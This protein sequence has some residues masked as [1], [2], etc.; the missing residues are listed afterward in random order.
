[1]AM[2]IFLKMKA[3]FRA[4]L[5]KLNTC[6]WDRPPARR[7]GRKPRHFHSELDPRSLQPPGLSPGE[8]ALD[9][10][11]AGGDPAMAIITSDA[12]ICE[13]RARSYFQLRS[14]QLIFPLVYSLKDDLEIKGV[15]E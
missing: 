4:S 5:K 2:K 10:A 3:G 12:R 6:T 13:L 7:L 15:K 1:M 14:K 9:P 8:R 11:S